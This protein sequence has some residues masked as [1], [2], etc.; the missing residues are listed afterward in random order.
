[1]TRQLFQLPSFDEVPEPHLRFHPDRESDSDTHPL[2]GLLQFGP[3]SRSTPFTA[4]DPIRLA[5]IGPKRSIPKVRAFI[6]ELRRS[7]TPKERS[8]YLLEY[9]GFS[10]VM[11]VGLSDPTPDTTISIDEDTVSLALA[12]PRPQDRL[13][14]IIHGAV[15]RLSDCRQKFDVALLYL[16]NQ[17]ASGFRSSPDDLT[18]DFDLHHSV[19]AQCGSIG[20]PIQ[21]LNDDALEYRCRCSVSWR[22]SI[23]LYVKAGGIPWKLLGYDDNHAYVGLS[24]CQRKSTQ[25]RFVTGCS[26][27]FDGRGTGLQF[28]L[29][30]SGDGHHAGEN[31]YLSRTDMYRLMS[32]TLGIY[33]RQRGKPPT[34]LVVHKTTPF[35]RDEI[36]GVNDAVSSI[37]D[38]ELLTI[39]EKTSWQGVRID[40]PRRTEESRGNAASYPIRRGTLMPLGIYEYLLW[41]SG[42]VG[43]IGDGEFFKEGKGIPKPLKVTRYQG[44]GSF[45]EG[46]REILGL[47]KMNWNNDSIYDRIP[48][49]L[50]YASVL[51]DV[52][53]RFGSLAHTPY[54]ARFFM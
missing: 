23:A 44:R 19:K 52:V 16:P 13:A 20:V 31:P 37:E 36:D 50:S 43:G 1:M 34:R 40:A 28:L 21:I 18:E 15:R 4:P 33:Q 22:L 17:W 42:V 47:T 41:S 35:Q 45:F 12:Q 27:M 3:Y 32:R 2:R 53:K 39:T 7:H 24:Y 46:A 29:Y 49:S 54:E 26:Q 30:E 11:R 9:P 5:V 38:V 25:H 10:A 51:A 48:V 8:Q 14:E 6:S